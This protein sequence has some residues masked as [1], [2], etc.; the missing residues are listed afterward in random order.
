MC[1]SMH[2]PNHNTHNDVINPTVFLERN[3]LLKY[4]NTLTSLQDHSL[5]HQHIL[6]PQRTEC[7]HVLVLSDELLI[8]INRSQF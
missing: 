2:K 8:A 4:Y 7:K 6:S 5:T 1:Q 3:R